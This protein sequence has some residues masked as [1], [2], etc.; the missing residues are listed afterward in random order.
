LCAKHTFWWSVCFTELFQTLPRRVALTGVCIDRLSWQRIPEDPHIQA[1]FRDDP[2]GSLPI[3]PPDLMQQDEF[4]RAEFLLDAMLENAQIF[5]YRLAST[6][7]HA[8]PETVVF[9]DSSFQCRLRF[10][11]LLAHLA[12]I[13]KVESVYGK[14][15]VRRQGQKLRQFQLCLVCDTWHP[16]T[17]GG[18]PGAKLTARCN[19]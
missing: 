10:G 1:H 6:Q 4:C 16:S 18:L 9:F 15:P 3:N 7:L 14:F 13:G 5:F 12:V 19:Q 11:D 2:G 8:Q 17:S